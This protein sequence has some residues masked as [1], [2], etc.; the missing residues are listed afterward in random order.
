MSIDYNKKRNINPAGISIVL[1]G[2]MWGSM[3]L[4]VR[5]LNADGLE[6]LDIV[7]I[8]VLVSS[9][10]MGLFL[11]FYDRSLFRIKL[12]DIW[13]F[14]GT[15]VFSLTFFNLCYFKTILMTSMSV[16]AILL[17][18]APIIVV[19]L[20]TIFFKEKITGLKILAMILTF[21]GCFFVTGIVESLLTGG[22]SAMNL[23]F[24]G[25]LIG[26]GSGLGYALYS[27]F[28]RFALEKGYKSVTISFYTFFFSL[29][30]TLVIRQPAEIV[31]TIIAG[32]TMRDLLLCVGIGLVTTVFPYLLYT[33]G[34]TKIEN[35]KASIM[36][37]V[38]PVVASLFGIVFFH[39]SLTPGGI[40]GVVLVLAALVLLNIKIEN[41]TKKNTK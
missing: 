10:I 23:S 18:T 9:I 6:S 31:S 24:K 20:S 37:S 39:E 2:I 12:K 8:R 34:L 17:Y 33:Y 3:G 22:M 30:A 21:I 13:C 28:S 16:A 36:A 26:L 40:I 11:V 38:E 7:E 32:E 41:C 14:I 25:I 1:A 4:F 5:G 29:L 15:G 35:G 27:I 19:L